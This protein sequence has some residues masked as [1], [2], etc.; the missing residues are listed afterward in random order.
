MT[1]K[2]KQKIMYDAAVAF[3]NGMPMNEVLST[4]NV[5]YASVYNAINRFN[6]PY[7]KTAGRTIFFNDDFF[8]TIDTEEKAYW[9]GFI[10]ADGAIIKTSKDMS[11]Y[12]RLS[13][14]LSVK[15]EK[16]LQK[17]AEAIE[18]PTEKIKHCLSDGNYG[19]HELCYLRCNSVK[20]VRDL[21]S[22]NCHPNKTYIS[23]YPDDIPPKLERHFIRGYFDGDGSISGSKAGLF[24]ITSEIY[25]LER[26]Q[27]TLMTNCALR[28]TKIANRKN[29][30]R[31]CYGGKLQLKRIF[32]FLYKDATVFL[33]RKYT[34]FLSYVFTQDET[35]SSPHAA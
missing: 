26:M 24:E 11:E 20:M 35:I 30:G 1:L 10:F 5:C 21:Q 7:K 34:K 14:C 16:H 9:L 27:N 32:D 3:V 23:S 12:N 28:K 19:M 15:D 13:I 6:I 2:E 25:A 17:F 29:T 22:H 8:H 33:E 31:L 18:Y 4:Y